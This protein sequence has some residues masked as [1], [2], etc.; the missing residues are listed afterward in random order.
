MN[1]TDEILLERVGD[2]ENI[3]NRIG[4]IYCH[5][6]KF[7]Y[8][9]ANAMSTNWV[10]TIWTQTRD[11]YHDCKSTTEWNNAEPLFYTKM[12]KRAYDEYK[13]DNDPDTFEAGFNIV[14]QDWTS[15]SQFKREITGGPVIRDYILQFARRARRTDIE[16]CIKGKDWVRFISK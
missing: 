7:A 14:L 11:L 4:V 16:N 1:E 12:K 2:A 9:P 15:I 3:A 6:V 5:F 8:L 13:K 10:H